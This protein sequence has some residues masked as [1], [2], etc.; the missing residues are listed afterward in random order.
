[1]QAL[2]PPFYRWE[3][4]VEMELSDLT[5]TVEPECPGLFPTRHAFKPVCYLAKYLQAQPDN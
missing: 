3:T 2:L 4:E 1:M 5:E